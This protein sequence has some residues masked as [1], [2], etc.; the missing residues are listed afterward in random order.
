MKLYTGVQRHEDGPCRTPT[1]QV[2]FRLSTAYTSPSEIEIVQRSSTMDV[3][4]F[5]RL[6]DSCHKDEVHGIVSAGLEAR[7]SP[8]VVNTLVDYYYHYE[9][10]E[11]LS[12]L[13]TLPRRRCKRKWAV[14]A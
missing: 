7:R 2:V 10:F 12:L 14:I 1:E 4:S 5:L 8:W 3:L 13:K 9:S 6:L 11:A